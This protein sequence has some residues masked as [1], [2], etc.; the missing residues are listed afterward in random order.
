MTLLALAIAA[1]VV[2]LIA[3]IYGFASFGA[4]WEDLHYGWLPVT[5]A[6]TVLATL[7][8]VI[9]YCAVMRADDGPRLA[10]PLVIRLVALG[11]GPFVPAGGFAVDKRALHAIEADERRARIRVL[12]LGAVEWALLAPAAWVCAV[13]LLV[14]G[15]PHPMPSLLWPWALAVPVGFAIGLWAAAP[16]R[17]E[18]FSGETEGWRGGLGDALQAIGTL[19]LLAREPRRHWRAWAGMA[20]YWALEIVAFYGAVRMAGLRPNAAETSLAYATGYALTRRS[21]PLGGAGATEALM[22]FALHWV[23]QPVV[24]ALV[25]VVIYRVFNFLLPVAPALLVRRRVRPLLTAADNER[26]PARRERRRAAAPLGR[27]S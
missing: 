9:G 12:G 27:S 15:D 14:V 1:A 10:L 26:V 19:H 5:F 22:T 18:R 24:P 7:G 3:G 2:V 8:Y 25:A 16:S 13:V 17:R 20:L 4:V 21:M 23:G 6:G 11:F